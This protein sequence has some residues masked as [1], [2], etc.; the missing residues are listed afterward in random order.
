MKKNSKAKIIIFLILIKLIFPCQCFSESKPF[1][2]KEAFST[3]L[4]VGSKETPEEIVKIILKNNSNKSFEK[5]KIFIDNKE[6]TPKVIE[7]KNIKASDEISL[8]YKVLYKN[9]N[10]ITDTLILEYENEKQIIKFEI[11]REELGWKIFLVTHFHYDP[12]WVAKRGQVEYAEKTF[13]LVK[14][15]IE[16]CKIYPYWTFVLHELSYL[17]P[18][19]DVFP[20]ER[21]ELIKLIKNK[22]LE[23][24]GGSYNQPDQAN[25]FGEGLI[26]NFIYGR[27]FQEKIMGADVSSGW[28]ID[29]FGQTPQYPQLLKKSGLS[30]FTF[31]RGGPKGFP[32][33][34]YWVSPDGTSIYCYDLGNPKEALSE[35]ISDFGK[36]FQGQSITPSL[37]KKAEEELLPPLI[38]KLKSLMTTKNVFIPAGDDFSPPMRELAF[39]YSYWSSKYISPQFIFITPNQFFE[40]V[41]KEIK[42]GNLNKKITS[43]PR[44][45]TKDLN[46]VFSGCYTS[47]I[48]LK[49]A[50]R[51]SENNLISAEKFST[52]AY[53]L[54]AN[55]P[56][57]LLDKSWRELIFNQHHDCIPGTSNELSNLDIISIYRESLELSSSVLNRAL[58]FI[59]KNI[60]TTFKIKDAKSIIIFNQLP[61]RRK[62]IVSID[63]DKIGIKNFQLRD[64]QGR[65]IPYTLED[66][67]ITFIADV[68]SFGYKIFYVFPSDKQ[69][70]SSTKS[71]GKEI[72]N[73]YYKILVSPSGIIESI[74]DK[75]NNKEIINKNSIY[76]ANEIIAQK[77]NPIGD[78]LWTISLTNEV[79]RSSLFPCTIKKEETPIY[80]KIIVSGK[81]L[82]CKRVQEIILCKGIKRIDFKT[83]LIG[84]TGKDYFYKVVFPLN[85]SEGA[86]LYDERFASIY[87][88][89]GIEF[90]AYNFVDYKEGIKISAYDIEGNSTITPSI[91]SCGIIVDKDSTKDKDSALFLMN[92]LSKLKITSCIFFD[93]PE[94]D[95]TLN[96]LIYIGNPFKNKNILSKFSK[97]EQEKLKKILHSKKLVYSPKD[98]I[99]II[100][101]GD[102]ENSQILVEEITKGLKENTC[103]VA[104]INN[105]NTGYNAENGIITLSLLRSPTDPHSPEYYGFNTTHQNWDHLFYYSL[106]PHL[107]EEVKLQEV[108]KIAE[109][110]NNPLF[111]VCTDLHKGTLREKELSFVNIEPENVFLSCFKL[112]GYPEAEYQSNFK[113]KPE[114]ILRVYEYAG[115]DTP[116]KISFFSPII[117]AYQSDFYEKEKGD[118]TP[119]QN[120]LYFK[121]SSFSVETFGFKTEKIIKKTKEDLD[122]KKESIQPV[123]SRFYKYNLGAEPLGNQ[124]V[125]ISFEK[126][127]VELKEK[128]SIKLKISSD[129]QDKTISGNIKLLGPS[130][131]INPAKIK[132]K[133]NSKDYKIFDVSIIPDKSVKSGRIFAFLEDAGQTYF[134]V[135]KIGEEN[136]ILDIKYEDEIILKNE[137]EEINI[138]LKNNSSCKVEG[139]IYIIS[140]VETWGE[141]S[142]LYGFIEITPHIQKIEILPN[143]EKI[144]NF[145]INTKNKL[146]ESFFAVVK[147]VYN[148][149][150]FYGRPIIIRRE[151]I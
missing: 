85:I 75:E 28:Q 130:F 92:A 72:E 20:E 148:G 52:I 104:L 64:Y 44:I 67:K 12:V 51:L 47:R 127:K 73:E 115:K 89:E 6:F 34:F 120:K 98:S 88:Q 9:E 81:F 126:E 111:V 121:I 31:L 112:K 35:V 124:P 103:G 42:E 102:L 143:E 56:S 71:R 74:Y 149:E 23:I 94:K 16:T 133:L 57:L 134:D 135:L 63:L 7:K 144:L 95:D 18:F 122:L 145:K 10:K 151:P 11:E 101:G 62:D 69:L 86:P 136:K 66:N 79:W 25:P 116:A 100:A 137:S 132:Y 3:G 110:F 141:I 117:K 90:P 68:P 40:I 50:N 82:K 106:F 129:Y 128:I 65:E 142:H 33:D 76:F 53:L 43:S 147:L 114:I 70:Y 13:D 8:K 105:G 39:I 118:I 87:R 38:K 55:Y 14:Q 24:V 27:T 46:P 146:S 17:K 21:E 107:S 19:W 78:S 2:L 77:E 96:I 125:S 54:G 109:E 138:S 108:K 4:F 15:Y 58:N 123:Y 5:I 30:S 37:I 99:L 26:R 80:S 140:P 29:C 22:K 41:E 150:V 49:I 83:Y 60:D 113:Y 32:S 48:D 93:K 36:T 1:I 59:S 91:K 84:Y 61:W 139:S 131:K 45:I 119:D 97:K